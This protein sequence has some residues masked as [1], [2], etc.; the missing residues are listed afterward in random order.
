MVHGVLQIWYNYN[1]GIIKKF[2]ITFES[3]KIL[4]EMFA[5]SES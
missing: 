1:Y 5:Y 2:E 3:K 4:K